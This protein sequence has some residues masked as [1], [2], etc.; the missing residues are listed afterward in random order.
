MNLLQKTEQIWNSCVSRAGKLQQPEMAE[1][2]W[3]MEINR[4]KNNLAPKYFELKQALEDAKIMKSSGTPSNDTW[5]LITLRPED[6]AVPLHRFIYDVDIFCKKSL[7][8]DGEW[9]FEQCGENDSESG[10]GF[11][12]HCLMKCKSYVN[13]KDIINAYKFIKYNCIIQVGR[14]DGKTKFIRNDKDLDFTRNY[15]NGDKHDDAKSA[16]CVQDKIWRIEKNIKTK[17]RKLE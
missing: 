3:K 16:R 9:V 2:F 7:F 12:A 5:C 15:I 6:G 8:L 13:V 17:Y 11:H 10:K 1:M 4:L 14:K